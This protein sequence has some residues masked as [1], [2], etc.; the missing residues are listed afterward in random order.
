MS[1][2]YNFIAANRRRSV[3]LVVVFIVLIIAIGWALEQGFGGDAS[4]LG[5]AAAISLVTALTGYFGGAQIALWTAHAIPV[6]KEQAPE[7][8]RTVENLSIASG[9]PMP[10][11]YVMDDPTINAFATGRD[12]NH[13]SV[14]VTRGALERLE[15]EELEGVLAHELSHI[16]NY[17]VRYMTLV[18]VLAGAIIIVSDMFWRTRWLR[19]DRQSR[20]GGGNILSLVGLLLLIFA[21]IIAQLIKLAV[22]RRREFLADASGALLTRYPEGLANAL[23]KIGQVNTRPMA[24]ASNA[25]AHLFITNPFGNGTRLS[26]L[27][28]T[29]PPLQERISALAAMAGEPTP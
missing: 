20:G 2:T 29:H 4:W 19:S 14:A 28:A 5:I 15:N 10:A 7:L 24:G 6:T 26:S 9:L 23:R 18:A 11:V 12:P 16:K 17:D 22:S 25:T 27:F 3:V 21:P 1:T 8:V 13:A